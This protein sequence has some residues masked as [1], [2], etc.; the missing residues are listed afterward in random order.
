MMTR[1]TADLF[2]ARQGREGATMCRSLAKGEKLIKVAIIAL[3]FLTLE[4]T[5][6]AGGAAPPKT[7]SAAKAAAA[8]VIDGSITDGEWEG[9][10]RLDLDHQTQPGDNSAPSERTEVFLSCD[11]EN[12]YVAFRAFDSDPQAIRSRVARREDIFS[13]DYVT[14]YL[15]T[16]DDRRRAYVF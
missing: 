8:P 3:I 4:T 11:R 12:L 14:I 2:S 7:V 6:P 10:A 13:D 16:Y 1:T 9:A 5:A 15:D